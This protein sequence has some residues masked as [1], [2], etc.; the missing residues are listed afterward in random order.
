MSGN[1]L[2][3][4][5]LSAATNNTSAPPAPAFNSNINTD[6]GGGLLSQAIASLLSGGQLG[7]IAQT[8]VPPL[9]QQYSHAE[10]SQQQ[11]LM[12]LQSLLAGQQQQQQQQQQNFLVQ[13]LGQ[14]SEQQHQLGAIPLSQPGQLNLSAFL[15]NQGMNDQGQQ[16]HQQQQQQ[17]QLRNPLFGQEGQ[18]T[19]QHRG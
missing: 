6:L 17:Q 13:Q 10:D 16:A 2:A 7:G 9:L 12:L 3:T 1:P 4:S 15:G 18:N 11:S 8:P 19:F 14:Q 5:L